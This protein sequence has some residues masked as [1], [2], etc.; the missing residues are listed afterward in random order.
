MNSVTELQRPM[1]T[2]NLDGKK[3]FEEGD[4]GSS[5]LHHRLQVLASMHQYLWLFKRERGPSLPSAVAPHLAE[6]QDQPSLVTAGK[7]SIACHLCCLQSD[8][9]LLP[10]CC[11]IY[12]YA[13]EWLGRHF[14]R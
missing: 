6:N 13:L 4:G 2:F 5:I 7:S 1:L 3:K 11:V 12:I 10:L 8:A 9:A 14:L